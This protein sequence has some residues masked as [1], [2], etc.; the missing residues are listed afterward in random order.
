[1]LSNKTKQTNKIID[2]DRSAFPIGRGRWSDIISWSTYLFIIT[3]NKVIFIRKGS[4]QLSHRNTFW[5]VKALGCIDESRP[6]HFSVQQISPPISSNT[7]KKSS[8][9]TDP[10]II[11]F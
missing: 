10:A 5:I 9:P 6:K 8:H 11:S 1:M 3:Q 7:N 2:G 4:M